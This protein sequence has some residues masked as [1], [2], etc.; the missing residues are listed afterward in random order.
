MPQGL[1]VSGKTAWLSGFRHRKGFGKRPCQLVRV[2]LV[3]GR[4]LQ[5]HSAIFGR[6]GHRPRTYCRHGGGI[7]QRGRWLWV[8]EKSKLWLVDPARKGSVLNAKR[9][10]RIEAPVRGSA[11][12]ATKTRIGL[13]PFQTGAGPHIYWFPIKALMRPGVLDL[14]VRRSG[15][16]QVGAVASTRIPRYTQGATLDSRGRLYLTRSSLACGELVTP[17]GR[18]EGLHPRRGRDPVRATRPASVDRERVRRPALLAARQAADPGG[19]EL[20]MATPAGRKTHRV[21]VRC[22]LTAR[23]GSQPLT[24]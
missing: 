6:V 14:A 22:P 18:R 19:G 4:R 8:A 15:R 11:I 20:R 23:P 9:V 21:R 16:S 12:V 13:V 1:A 2:D 24:E 3:S 7:L 5:F 10:W 17:S